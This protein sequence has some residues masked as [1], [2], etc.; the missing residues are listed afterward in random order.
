MHTLTIPFMR[1]QIEAE[2]RKKALKNLLE[3][4]EHLVKQ[5]VSADSNQETVSH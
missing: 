2:E 3:E 5:I 4:H 1:F